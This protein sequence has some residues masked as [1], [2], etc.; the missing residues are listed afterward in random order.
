MKPTDLFCETLSKCFQPV[1]IFHLNM[2][3]RS[4]L[5]RKSAFVDRDEAKLV[6]ELEVAI[7]ASPKF[8]IERFDESLQSKDMYGNGTVSRQHVIQVR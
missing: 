3:L 2:C 7:Q 4:S 1:F 5:E 8:E 6:L